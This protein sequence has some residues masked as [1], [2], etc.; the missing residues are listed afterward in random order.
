M[1]R[2]QKG[3]LAAAL[4]LT[5]LSL[6]ACN[7]KSDTPSATAQP[8]S[9]AAMDSFSAADFNVTIESVT[10]SYM[11]DWSALQ[12]ALGDG[13]EVSASPSCDY[14]GDDKSFIYDDITIYT[15]PVDGKDVLYGI[16]L[17]SAKYGT[18]KDVRVGDKL[19]DIIA[20]YGSGY[21]DDEPADQTADP[22]N[23]VLTYVLGADNVA[24]RCPQLLFDMADGV[25]TCVTYYCNG[26]TPQ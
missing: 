3:L 15:V 16:E 4:L 18:S 26:V 22:G 23:G 5:P 1:N 17:S 12:K 7:D 6:T 21:I 9:V 2:M 13:Y 10:A 8:T 14:V 20:A 24:A 25:V 11:Q 19:E